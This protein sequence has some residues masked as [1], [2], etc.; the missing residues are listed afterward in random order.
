MKNKV[1]IITSSISRNAGGLYDAMR[2]LALNLNAPVEIFGL[3][4][5]YTD[6]D[7]SG[8]GEVKLNTFKTSLFHSFGYAPGLS[9]SI[10][11]KK[12]EVLHL[13]GLWMY[14]QWV[15]YSWQRKERS[16]V[17]ISTHG[18][19][20]AWA[21]DISSW[22]KNLVGRAF[23]FKSL[24]RASCIHAL[25]YSEYEAVRK[26]GLKNPVAVIPNGIS[27]PSYPP[28]KASA[29]KRKTLLYL[30]RLHP[31]KGLDLL[32]EALGIIKSKNSNFFENWQV[33]LVGGGIPAHRESLVNSVLRLGLENDVFFT[34]PLYNS[35]KEKELRTA[36]AYILPSYSEG[37][38]VSVL[39]AWSYKLPVLMTEACNLNA[40]FDTK[41]AIKLE[42]QEA[43]IAEKIM[44]MGGLDEKQLV[45]MGTNGFRLVQSNF[46]WKNIAEKFEK[47]YRWLIDG[48]SKPD[49]IY[50][51]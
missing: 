25:C 16:P 36:S 9:K 34:G 4:D 21:L 18:M 46:D 13:H 7:R 29:Q 27:I 19:L 20:N 15:T 50:T 8:W 51:D 28:V 37:I 5:E 31:I 6:S 12:I 1:A 17:I 45:E 38:P 14:P 35:E 11:Q 32:I 3:Q 30:G 26:F 33:K 39:E 44:K 2:C 10:H 43:D 47:T 22:K 40:G 49:F 41:A 23:A 48:K 42:L 24:E